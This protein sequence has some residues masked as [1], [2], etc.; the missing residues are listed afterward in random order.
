M[1]RSSAERRAQAAERRK[2]LKE[3]RAT[4][5]RLHLV[6]SLETEKAC[7]T[8]TVWINRG[9][10]RSDCRGLDHEEV[11]SLRSRIYNGASARLDSNGV[12]RLEGAPERPMRRTRAVASPDFE[13][14]LARGHCVDLAQKLMCHRDVAARG[15]ESVS[16]DLYSYVAPDREGH[17]QRMQYLKEA[18]S[19]LSAEEPGLWFPEPLIQKAKRLERAKGREEKST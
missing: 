19:K 16:H 12:P 4:F 10:R 5:A 3:V 2:A 7:T 11:W 8:L 14:K 18:A 1:K 17:K 6:P 15:L 9:C 13:K